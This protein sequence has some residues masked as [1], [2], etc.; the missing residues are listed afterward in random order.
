[1]ASTWY[2]KGLA[3][4]K[5]ILGEQYVEKQ[6]KEADDFN[7]PLQEMVTEYCWGWLWNRPGL[8]KKTRSMLNLAL[9]A[10]LNRHQEFK[11]HVKGALKNGCTRG[12]ISEVLLQVAMYSGIPAGVEAFRLAR[13]AFRELDGSGA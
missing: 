3:L 2:D 10:T 6:L 8:P 7:Q 11:T 9:L 12:E 5:E 13:E 4:R 1:M